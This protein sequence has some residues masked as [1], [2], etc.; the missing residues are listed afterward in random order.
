MS[1]R[2]RNR[3]LE[4]LWLI[5][6]IAFVALVVIPVS[7]RITKIASVILFLALW[8]GVLRWT[9]RRRAGRIIALATSLVAI[10]F[11][12]LPGRG[13]SQVAELRANYIT[14]LLRYDQVP[15]VWGG[16]SIKGIDCS[17]LIRRGLIDALFLRGLSQ[18]DASLV[19]RSFKLWWNDTSARALGELHDGL[20]VK[21][22]DTP[23]LNEL[24]H[25]HVLPGDLAVT[26]NG[27][28]IMAYLGGR[29]W[30]EADPGEGRVIRVST[31]S[32][33]SWFG[34]PMTVVR[35]S[36]LGD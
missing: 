22:L 29:E 14:G 28:H 20:T 27:V 25:A 26:R 1:E 31:P 23:S 36:V 11:V 13:H 15:Y 3:T 34:A 16:E 32:K 35:W 12:C 24:D 30:I 9:W 21:I 10:G 4:R 17:G 33:N 5:C 2:L 7:S 6:L 8:A 18:L 19:R